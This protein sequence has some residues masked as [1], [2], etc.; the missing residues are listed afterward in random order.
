MPRRPWIKERATRECFKSPII[1][2][3]RFSGSPL[4]LRIVIKSKSAW[5]GCACVPSPAFMTAI[6]GVTRLAMKKG[7]PPALWRTTKRSAC[8]ASR[9]FS[10]SNSVSPLDA[11]LVRMSRVTT[12]ALSLCAAISNV[13]RVRVEFSKN[14]FTTVFPRRR[15]TFFTGCPCEERNVSAVSRSSV[16]RDFG[17]PSV[18]RRCFNRP[19]EVSWSAAGP[20][21]AFLITSP[22]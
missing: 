9:F 19:S 10:V 2:T 21:M 20:C 18:V 7:A 4:C 17:R 16:M 1:A 15:G 5:V 13:V 11:E 12:S 22:G 3:D 14:K 6:F 8:I